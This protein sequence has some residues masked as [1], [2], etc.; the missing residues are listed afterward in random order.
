MS[1]DT[2]IELLFGKLEQRKAKIA[3]L[4]ANIAKGWVTIGSFKT[5]GALAPTNIQTA[6]QAV[7]EEIAVHI[8]MISAAMEQAGSRLQAPVSSK[9]QGFTV[10]EWFQDLNKRLSTI[11]LREEEAAIAQI[12]Q[13]LN[14]VLSPEQRRKIEVELLAREL[15]VAVD[16][17]LN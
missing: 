2:Q 13:R 5:V 1:I 6:S 4:K 12:E 10:D 7:V 9:I 16:K 14:Q 3:E 11:Q 8:C 17:D 15:D